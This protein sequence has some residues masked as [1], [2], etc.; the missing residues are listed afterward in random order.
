MTS[1]TYETATASLGGRF[2]IAAFDCVIAADHVLEHKPSPEPYLAAARGLSVEPAAILVFEDSSTGIRSAYAA[3][4]S[5]AGVQRVQGLDRP[6]VQPVPASL[7]LSVDFV[8]LLHAPRAMELM[9]C[10]AGGPG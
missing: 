2:D 7:G 8:D 5:G 6:M 1:A 3:G 4:C 9:G 10:A